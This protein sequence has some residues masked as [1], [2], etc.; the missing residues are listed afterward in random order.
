LKGKPKLTFKPSHLLSTVSWDHYPLVS[1]YAP[2]PWGPVAVMIIVIS[3]I[4]AVVFAYRKLR[5]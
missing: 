1:G 2:F 3:A 5:G 4:P